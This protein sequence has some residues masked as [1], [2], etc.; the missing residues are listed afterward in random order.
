MSTP[1]TRKKLYNNY[2]STGVCVS[3]GGTR[4]DETVLQCSICITKNDVY[5][6]AKYQRKKDTGFC[7]S[8]ATPAK[9]GRTLCEKHLLDCLQN[10]I[11]IKKEVM[12]YYGGKC[13]ACGDER[14]TVLTLDH[15][16][17]NGRQ[18]RKELDGSSGYRT[19]QR[20]YRWLKKQ[21]FKTPYRLQV[22]CANCHLIK[23]ASE[24]LN[25]N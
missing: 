20:L 14:L 22:L 23:H 16:D 8:C 6:K 21:E 3:C 1:A 4:R 12:Q 18:H 5:R 13:I 2:R 17:N 11:S 7:L 19:G 25:G 15:I 10:N 24:E 9:V